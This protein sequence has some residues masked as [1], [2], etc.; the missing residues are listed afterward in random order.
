MD[1]EGIGLEPFLH[2]TCQVNIAAVILV[3]K[4]LFTQDELKSI[5]ARP[6]TCVKASRPRK[7]GKKP[8]L[9]AFVLKEEN[10]EAYLTCMLK[11]ERHL[12]LSGVR[13]YNDFL[14]DF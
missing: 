11:D 2:H 14:I 9:H 6:G 1:P 3:I 4:A 7:G 8:F 13:I 10:Q 5:D 12:R